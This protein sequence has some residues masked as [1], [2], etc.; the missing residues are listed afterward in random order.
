[1]LQI[2]WWRWNAD[3]TFGAVFVDEVNR[4]AQS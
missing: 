4:I 2:S 1:V 3:R